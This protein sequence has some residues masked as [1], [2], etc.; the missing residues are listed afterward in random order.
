[1]RLLFAQTV[2]LLL[3]FVLSLHCNANASVVCAIKITYL[4]TYLE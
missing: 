3:M 1:M 2:G 4:F